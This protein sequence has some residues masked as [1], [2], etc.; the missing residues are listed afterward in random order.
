[1]NKKN[2]SNIILKKE[3]D[4]FIFYVAEPSI[5]HRSKNLEEGYKEV[6]EKIL[7]FKTDLV[8]YEFDIK[9]N[10]KNSQI[11]NFL[12]KAS[13]IFLGLTFLISFSG[14]KILSK[15]NEVTKGIAQDL[16]IEDK[17]KQKIEELPNVDEDRQERNIERIRKIVTFLKPYYKE[18][19]KIKD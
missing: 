14:I 6:N 8:K 13:I 10:Q 15:F 19:T 12:L 4:E 3:N 2:N 5:I 16:N 7:N 11:K 1:M 18:I 17:I 9:E